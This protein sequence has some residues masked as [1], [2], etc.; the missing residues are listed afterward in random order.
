M[1]KKRE[2]SRHNSGD[3]FGEIFVNRLKPNLS[4][5]YI[6][7]IATIFCITLSILNAVFLFNDAQI[8]ENTSQYIEFGILSALAVLNLVIMSFFLIRLSWL[9]RFKSVSEDLT[10][11]TLQGLMLYDRKGRFLYANKTAED[12]APVLFKNNE[13]KNIEKLIDFILKCD[14]DESY[15]IKTH[16]Q[17][18]GSYFIPELKDFRHIIVVS[19]VS[20]KSLLV[21]MQNDREGHLVMIT[22]ISAVKNQHRNMHELTYQNQLL[23]FSAEIIPNGIL[24]FETHPNG[25][26]I[27]YANNAFCKFLGRPLSK[28][29]GRRFDDLVT[30]LNIIDRD[31][32]EDIY[33]ALDK[34]ET[35]AHFVTLPDYD[36]TMDPV[37][38]LHHRLT[39][40]RKESEKDGFEAVIVTQNDITDMVLQETRLAQSHKLEALGKLSG[41]IA[42]DFN[43]ILSIIDGYTLLLLSKID[44][45]GE[46]TEYLNRISRATQKGSKLTRQLLSFGR[47]KVFRDDN[48]IDLVQTLK[49]QATLIKPLLN[50]TI[51][52]DLKIPDTPLYIES[53]ADS[54]PRILI[55]MSVNSRDAMPEGG[56]LTISAEAVSSVKS[57]KTK[58]ALLR[59][60]DTGH[61]IDEASRN[62]IFDPFY[63][64]KDQGKGTGLGLS[65]VYGLV[66]QMNGDIEFTTEAGKGTEF[67]I[68]L[69]LTN[70]K[71]TSNIATTKKSGENDILAGKTVLL[72]EDEPDILVI[73]EKMLEGMGLEVLKALNG[74]EALSVQDEY[75][76]NIDFLV[77]DVVMPEMNG[78][79][80]SKLIRE[81]H[82]DIQVLF[83]TGYP[84]HSE[85]IKV[86]IPKEL[87]LLSKPVSKEVLE[88]KLVAMIQKSSGNLHKDQERKIVSN[89]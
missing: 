10:Q 86:T 63:T 2:S 62:K 12:L 72:A 13:H 61:G 7:I 73:M 65:M 67:R 88:A 68:Y 24:V 29:A 77:S 26:F 43:N 33:T 40:V 45:K 46:E 9:R 47:Q 37:Q 25:N 44:E 52:F 82:P 21:Q 36:K 79:H 49:E 58:A 64:T 17:I 81:F 54:I 42:H 35:P 50:E 70:K 32:L 22:D 51:Q 19:D 83:I 87:E 16:N 85:N 31:R 15:N 89:V 27:A 74:N 39:F 8:S 57:G 66:K 14:T 48:I 4:K 56:K 59:I 23:L 75:E 20:K 1:Q 30:E 78:L 60:S 28:V 18:S 5:N 80:L 34:G 55:N 41:G 6:L 53:H 84:A 69:P 71:T 3:R 76:G 11:S 38:K